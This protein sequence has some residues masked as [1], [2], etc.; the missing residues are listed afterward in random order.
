VDKALERDFPNGYFIN[1]CVNAQI[2]PTDKTSAQVTVLYLAQCAYKVYATNPKPNTYK[3]VN[4]N[5]EYIGNRY[6]EMNATVTCLGKPRGF[7]CVKVE[8]IKN[9]TP[10]PSPPSPPPVGVWIPTP[11][12]FV[13]KDIQKAGFNFMTKNVK[14]TAIAPTQNNPRAFNG[15]S[16]IGDDFSRKIDTNGG[17]TYRTSAFINT[18]SNVKGCDFPFL[19]SEATVDVKK[20]AGKFTFSNLTESNYRK[21][22]RPDSGAM[23]KCIGTPAWKAGVTKIDRFCKIVKGGCSTVQPDD[24]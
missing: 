11:Y 19:V 8:S 6:Y 21:F 20:A 5:T 16:K 9:V 23:D 17:V 1:D 10:K 2:T 14:S 18:K 12:M 3:C 22:L 13:P 4:E 15:P 7:P 24:K